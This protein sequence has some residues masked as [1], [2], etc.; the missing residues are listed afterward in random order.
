[1]GNP[2]SALVPVAS[3]SPVPKSF[4]HLIVHSGKYLLGH[5]RFEVITPSSDF[6]IKTVNEC[7]LTHSPHLSNLHFEVVRM[8]L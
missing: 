4:K 2:I 8:L 3:S 5:K 7:F 6:R 1:M